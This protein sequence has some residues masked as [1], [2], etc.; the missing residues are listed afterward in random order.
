MGSGLVMRYLFSLRNYVMLVICAALISGL[1]LS[2]ARAQS[3]TMIN[4]I[5]VRGNERVSTATILSYLPIVLGDRVSA[6]SLNSAVDSLFQTKLFEDVTIAL[7][8]DS[9]VIEVEENPIVNKQEWGAMRQS[10]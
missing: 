5:I 6:S 3:T 9:L 10:L 8:D 4:E 2:I 1:P 7:N